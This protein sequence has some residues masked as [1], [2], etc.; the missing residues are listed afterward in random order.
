MRSVGHPQHATQATASSA[1]ISSHQG[2]TTCVN[3]THQT[4]DQAQGGLAEGGHDAVGNAVA[5]SRL[6]EAT[7]QEVGD[8]DQPAA[9][10][11]NSSKVSETVKHVAAESTT[12]MTGGRYTLVKVIKMAGKVLQIALTGSRWRRR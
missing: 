9:E 7:S 8:C 5:Q 10:P 4:V 11:N 3:C 2:A 12:E 6:D 1:W